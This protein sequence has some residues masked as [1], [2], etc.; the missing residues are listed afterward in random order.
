M[1]KFALVL[2]AFIATALTSVAADLNEVWNLIIKEQNLMAEYIEGELARKN[3]FES[4]NV[5][6][7]SAPTSKD[8]AAIEAYAKLI[9]EKQKLTSVSEEGVSVSMFA[10]PVDAAGTFYRLLILVT[11]D[12]EEK[13]LICL[14]G[15]CTR[16]QMTKTL[17]GLSIKN[18]IGD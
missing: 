5:A 12:A 4:L 13:A 1:K 3:G 7:N 14:Y 2:T 9:D 18:I 16:D 11:S 6:L 17:E 8:I 10:S 15:K